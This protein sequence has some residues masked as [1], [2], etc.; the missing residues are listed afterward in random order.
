MA[1][2]SREQ[3][4]K[5]AL[6]LDGW[7]KGKPITKAGD[8]TTFHKSGKWMTKI[9][10]AMSTA[11]REHGFAK[12]NQWQFRMDREAI[13]A[14]N[15]K[16][17]NMTTTTKK[18]TTKNATAKKTTEPKVTKC[19]PAKAKGIKTTAD[20]PSAKRK[21]IAAKKA[22]A[23]KATAK[24][25]TSFNSNTVIVKTD[26]KITAPVRQK[27]GKLV[28]KAGVKVS[29]LIEKAVDADIGSEERIKK[30]ITALLGNGRFAVKS[31]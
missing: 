26:K 4:L 14:A 9:D 3:A 16:E 17:G 20:V 10:P 5:Q 24:K 15:T 23:K 28:P 22:T 13:T 1:T 29:V 25:A 11:L 21:S 2:V 8:D 7:A 6:F 31:K 12:G 27:I 30:H 19:P 18:T